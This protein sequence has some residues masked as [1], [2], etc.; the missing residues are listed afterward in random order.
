MNANHKLRTI[1]C[2]PQDVDWKGSRC[3]TERLGERVLEGFAESERV[4]VG[5][6]D[7]EADVVAF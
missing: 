7:G 5:W 3:E 1:I 6:G 4:G 2:R